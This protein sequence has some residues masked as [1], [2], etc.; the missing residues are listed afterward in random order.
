MWLDT[1]GV[2]HVLSGRAIHIPNHRLVVSDVTH[3]LYSPFVLFAVTAIAVAGLR[4]PFMPATLLLLSSLGW[5]LVA[6][7]AGVVAAVLFQT[8]GRDVTVGMAHW[9]LSTCVLLS[10]LLLILST[11]AQQKTPT[12]RMRLS[13]ALI[14]RRI[15]ARA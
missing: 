15:S 2:N 10:V 14:S 11:V 9:L 3:T 8:Q 4:Y 13:L 12:G 6:N 1:F 7:I 5:A